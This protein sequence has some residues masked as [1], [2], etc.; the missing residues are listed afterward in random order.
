[1]PIFQILVTIWGHHTSSHPSICV[2][3]FETI[4]EADFACESILQNHNHSVN[5][6]IAKV[7]KLYDSNKQK[8][9]KPS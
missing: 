6:P 1:M 2:I 5:G 7:T 3:A 8:E 4:R 9:E